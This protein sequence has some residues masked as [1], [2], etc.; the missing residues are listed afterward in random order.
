MAVAGLQDGAL[1][2][3]FDHALGERR[4]QAFDLVIDP[5]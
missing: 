2:H 1:F 3:F 4:T 5:L